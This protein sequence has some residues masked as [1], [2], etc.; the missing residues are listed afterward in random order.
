MKLILCALLLFSVCLGKP[1]E[2]KNQEP[3][4]GCQAPEDCPGMELWCD[5]LDGE[6]KYGCDEQS[7]CPDGK[8]CVVANHM[9]QC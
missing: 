6:C 8:I 5:T 3:R 7:D 9:C 4:E 2:D 1:A